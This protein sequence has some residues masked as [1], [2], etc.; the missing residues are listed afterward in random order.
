MQILRGKKE[1]QLVLKD[2][3][4]LFA[5]Y[6]NVNE[7]GFWE[8]DVY[9]LLRKESDDSIA[10]TFNLTVSQLYRT[11]SDAKRQLLA[12]R[13]KRA[14]PGLDDKTLTSWNALML[15]AYVDAYNAFGEQHFLEMAE[16]NADFILQKQNNSTN[17]LFHSYTKDRASINGYLEDYS[18][19]IEAVLALYEATF[20]EVYLSQAD[21][22]MRYCKIHFQDNDSGL[23]FFTSDE[24]RAL[25]ARKMELTDNV[26]PSSNSSIAKSL[27]KLGHHLEQNEYIATSRKMLNNV[28]PEMMTYPEG[29][30]NWA[31]LL[32]YYANPFYEIS[33]VGKAVDEKR[34]SFNEHYLPNKI[35]AGSVSES[36][37]PLLMGKYVSGQTLIYICNN[38][39]CNA[40]VYEISDALHQLVI[41]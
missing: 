2:Q 25:I 32:L 19:C 4:E 41:A 40:P 12:A 14:R 39:T 38:N 34:K 37:L 1:L 23:F 21:E 36:K 20:K 10:A 13:N 11:L 28:I 26:V 6:Y 33:I 31:M 16:R 9:I 3:F 7:I 30:S 24:D 22:W 15:H 17:Q 29:Y 18:F 8:N 35:F 27:Y 5:A